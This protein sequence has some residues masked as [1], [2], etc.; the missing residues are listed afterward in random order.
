VRIVLR[1]E[2]S[3]LY[4][5]YTPA[6]EKVIV[7]D[8]EIVDTG[9]KTRSIKIRHGGVWHEFTDKLEMLVF[10]LECLLNVSDDLV[11]NDKNRI[12]GAPLEILHA[13]GFKVK[14]ISFLHSC[15]TTSNR[16]LPF[17]EIKQS[18]H[19]LRESRKDYC[20][21][22]TCTEAQKRDVVKEFDNAS[23]VFVIP[24]AISKQYR[25]DSAKIPANNPPKIICVGR[26]APVKRLDQAIK[27]F[28]K[29]HRQ[30]PEAELHLF[31][32]GD[33]FENNLRKLARELNLEDAV[34]LRGYV[35]NLHEEYLSAKLIIITSRM[36]GFHMG[37]LE[38][39]AH[40]IPAVS[41][42]AKY[43]PM[44]LIEN[45]KTG[46]LTPMTTGD[47]CRK[48]VLLLRDEEMHREFSDNAYE[49]SFEFDEEKIIQRWK[50]LFDTLGVAFAT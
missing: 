29:V 7:K 16:S 12:Y 28:A 44:D 46:F 50:S 5:Y 1:E 21:I 20:A 10:F 15:H 25:D 17:P 48:V 31:G 2:Q 41:F 40:G 24:H 32:F 14:K 22:I 35:A 38:A 36:E 3:L 37:L 26:Y 47:L 45:G 43:G 13:K 18:H 19:L 4:E 8:Y 49:K 11:I 9:A 6:G 39:M 23:Q 33:K 42:N 34:K 30:I 27:A